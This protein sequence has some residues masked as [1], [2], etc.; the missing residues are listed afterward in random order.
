[1]KPL[2]YLMKVLAYLMKRI[3]ETNQC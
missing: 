1:M 3:S 2:A